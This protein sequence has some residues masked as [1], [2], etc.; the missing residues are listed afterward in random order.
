MTVCGTAQFS[1]LCGRYLLY[2]SGSPPSSKSL[3]Q[4]SQSGQVFVA[5]KGSLSGDL[6]ER[7]DAS[8]IRATRHNRLQTTIDGTEEHP[9]LTPS[10]V[11]FDQLELTT[12]QGMERMRYP[13][14]FAH[15][16]PMRCS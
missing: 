10:F 12:E 11:I 5:K 1:L 3:Q 14:I 4:I 13:K 16:A 9:I 2:T 6:Y 15:T 8:D 7:V